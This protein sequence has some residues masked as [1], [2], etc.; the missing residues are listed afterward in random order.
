MV[1]LAIF[2]QL[3]LP[4]SLGCDSFGT[5]DYDIRIINNKLTRVVLTAKNVLDGI[6]L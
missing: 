5:T 1:H 2:H 6:G 4:N 3:V